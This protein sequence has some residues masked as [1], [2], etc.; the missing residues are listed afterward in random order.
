MSAASLVSQHQACLGMSLP[1]QHSPHCHGHGLHVVVG[2]W[3]LLVCCTLLKLAPPLF[4]PHVNRTSKDSRSLLEQMVALLKAPS[5]VKYLASLVS[6][7]PAADRPWFSEV[8]KTHTD[9]AASL[10]QATNPQSQPHT[11]GK[12]SVEQAKQAGAAAAA[13]AVNPRGGGRAGAT[14][15]GLAPALM[16]G[17]PA[18]AGRGPA[19]GAGPLQGGGKQG[20]LGVVKP[21]AQQPLGAGARPLQQQ[22]LHQQQL[23]VKRPASASGGP[24]S[25]L[26]Q[27]PLGG[28]ASSSVSAPTPGAQGTKG[29]VSS[30]GPAASQQGAAAKKPRT[31]SIT[32]VWGRSVCA[33]QPTR[34][35]ME[36]THG[37]EAVFV[38]AVFRWSCHKLCC[39]PLLAHVI[40]SSASRHHLHLTDC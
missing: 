13:V 23:P 18:G 28:G 3:G 39:A 26:Q 1:A 38:C 20:G 5:T 40:C 36:D 32:G 17:K 29:A 24:A 9:R 2:A 21:G 12:Q 37:R 14:A 30:A 34:H 27:R 19:G 15:P 22:Q 31:D 6:F 8:V 35:W 10:S 11:Q 33:L 25:G 4:F 7:I 16:S